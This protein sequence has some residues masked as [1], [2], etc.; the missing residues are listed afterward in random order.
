MAE[1]RG[2][3]HFIKTT[4]IGGLLFLVPVGVLI[5]VLA[6]VV[7]LMLMVAEPL[8]DFIPVDSVAGVAVANIVA[9]IIL[10]LICFVAGMIARRT[11]V[12]SIVEDLESDLR[13]PKNQ[14]GHLIVAGPGLAGLR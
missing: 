1:K 3:I 9:A 5:I 8:A 6:K 4:I 14:A 10:V 12:S 13:S 2:K 7:E 11:V